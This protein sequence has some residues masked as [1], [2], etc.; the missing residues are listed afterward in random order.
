MEASGLPFATHRGVV[1]F[2]SGLWPSPC[3]GD[4]N[5]GHRC[6]GLPRS[7]WS[8]LAGHT[9]DPRWAGASP[10]PTQVG[11]VPRRDVDSGR[12]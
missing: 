8:T 1:S 4:C 11:V 12:A 9:P 5:T 7:G 2:P 3:I 6:V 10:V